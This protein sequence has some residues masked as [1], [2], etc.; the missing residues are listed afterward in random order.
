M[1]SHVFSATSVQWCIEHSRIAVLNRPYHLF[2]T[3]THNKMRRKDHCS[4]TELIKN[5]NASWNEIWRRKRQISYVSELH[6]FLHFICACENFRRHADRWC[7]KSLP[8]LISNRNSIRKA[9]S[10]ETCITALRP[11]D[12]FTGPCY[13]PLSAT[14]WAGLQSQ[15]EVDNLRQISLYIGPSDAVGN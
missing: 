8:N 3:Q 14:E 2:H 10:K 7:K 11:T 15:G 5:T 6:Q 4:E 12:E 9:Q 1:R 13:N